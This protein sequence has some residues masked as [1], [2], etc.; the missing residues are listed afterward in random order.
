MPL[1]TDSPTPPPPRAVM[2]SAP[3]ELASLVCT[4]SNNKPPRVEV[5][6][7]LTDRVNAFWGDG[8]ASLAEVVVLAH[9][10]GSLDDLEID[11]FLERLRDPAPFDLRPPLETETPDERAAIHARLER[12]MADRRL[13]G[14]YAALLRELWDLFAARWDAGGRAE[15]EAVA[16]DWSARL[17]AGADALDLLP[18]QHIARRDQFPAMVRRARG[19]GELRVSP[20][21]AGHGHI[22]A[23]PGILSVA[24]AAP[25]RDPVVARRRGADEIA[26]LLRVLSDPTRLTILTQLA[27]APLGVSELARTLHIAQPTAS[28]HLRRLREAGLVTAERF[29][30]RSVYSARPAAVEDLMA[31]VTGRLGRAMA[32]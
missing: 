25:E 8:F 18:E 7:R 15:A 6:A 13:R 4:C 14:R 30:S 23:L 31:E 22:V 16:A 29:G 27:H 26:E 28:V 3:M 20:S 17:A 32:G 2:A 19:R 9:A 21:I 5:P 24:A 10:T 11:G 1:D 12:F